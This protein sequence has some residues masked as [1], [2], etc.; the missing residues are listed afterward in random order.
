[1]GTVITGASFSWAGR[2]SRDGFSG[3]SQQ[4]VSIDFSDSNDRHLQR[5]IF[6]DVERYSRGFFSGP[7]YRREL[8]IDIEFDSLD[9]QVMKQVVSW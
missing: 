4:G 5:E 9:S 2:I 8:G 1:M 7:G 3:M 6:R